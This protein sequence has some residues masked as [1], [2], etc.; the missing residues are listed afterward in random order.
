MREQYV[1]MRLSNQRGDFVKSGSTFPCW[2]ANER[3]PYRSSRLTG[4]FF[5]GKTIRAVRRQLSD[6]FTLDWLPDGMAQ[7]GLYKLVI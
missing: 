2:I 5:T 6:V 4:L 7:M 3:H 1:A